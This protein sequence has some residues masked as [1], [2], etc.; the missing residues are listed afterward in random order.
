MQRRIDQHPIAD[1]AFA[2]P[3]AEGEH[4][5]GDVHPGHVREGEAGQQAGT[6]AL[7]EVEP[8]HRGGADGDQH[9]ARARF[10]I[11]Q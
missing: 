5:A 6:A 11:G 9:F 4:V 1:P 10:G 2:H 7:Q 8:V 3:F